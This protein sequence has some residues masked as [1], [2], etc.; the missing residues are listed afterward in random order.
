MSRI[1]WCVVA[2]VAI[3]PLRGDEPQLELR[4]VTNSIGMELIELPSGTFTRGASSNDADAEE[5]E[6]PVAEI[7]LDGNRWL[8][9]YE[10]TQQQFRKVMG[11]NPAWFGPR[12]PA[13]GLIGDAATDDWPIDN[14]S[15]KD[16]V[17]FCRKLS[18]LGEEKQAGRAYRLPTE[19]EW[20]Y[21]CRAGTTSRYSCGEH[22]RPRDACFGDLSQQAHPRPVGSYPANPWGFH[23]LHGNVWEWCSDRYSPEAYANAS[24]SP[25]EEIPGSTARVVRGGDWRASAAY[26]RSSNRDLTRESRRDVGNGFRVLCEVRKG[27]DSGSKVSGSK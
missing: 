27:E 18:E 21:A 19:S 1:S 20:E 10:V 17:E 6:F 3:G 15:W 4:H 12:G 25:I 24:R 9:K 13:R 16:A 11:F 5:D 14:A 7:R 23:D 22:L 2:L 8:G 26:C